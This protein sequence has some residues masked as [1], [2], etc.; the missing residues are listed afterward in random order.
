MSIPRESFDSTP[1]P[2]ASN[3]KHTPKLR[4]RKGKVPK[5]SANEKADKPGFDA[6]GK[7]AKGNKGGPGNPFAGQVASHRMVCFATIGPDR[8]ARALRITYNQLFGLDSIADP[9]DRLA[10]VKWYSDRAMGRVPLHVLVDEHT[11]PA[12]KDTDPD[13]FRYE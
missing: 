9:K 10:W 8:Y 6:R 3:A 2:T 4:G 13:A 12:S 7:F 1:D 5:T 11:G